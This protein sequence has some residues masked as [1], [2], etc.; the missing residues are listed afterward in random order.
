MIE[1]KSFKIVFKY[2][3]WLLSLL[4]AISCSS[5]LT[6]ISLSNGDSVIEM[7]LGLSA[8]SS[9]AVTAAFPEGVDVKYYVFDR[10][11][12]K[13][14]NTTVS[15]NLSGVKLEIRTGVKEVWA[16]AGLD[17]SRLDSCT[18]IDEFKSQII[19]LEDN[20][21][22]GPFPSSGT[23]TVFAYSKE[24]AEVKLELSYFAVRINVKEIRNA[25]SGPL[26]GSPI[27]VRGFFLTNVPAS[28]KVDGSEPE[29]PGYC[30]IDGRS[31][32]GNIISGKEDADLPD[33]TYLSIDKPCAYGSKLL[34]DAALLLLPNEG[35]GCITRAVA[36][37]LIGD[38]RFFY[39]V[40]L[41]GLKRN[42]SYNL[43]IEITRPG[44]SDPESDVF[45]QAV[46]VSL[47]VQNFI[48]APDE[49]T[50]VF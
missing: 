32:Q 34:P 37:V 48:D 31:S 39:P 24:M 30:N 17:F 14:E 20:G 50:V 35:G 6:D 5:K 44:S 49:I 40:D 4:P 22:D 26:S 45:G 19:L 15:S 2:A 33:L 9:A 42:H 27:Q 18:D 46:G 47:E 11:G 8:R 7:E 10:E 41:N 36:D 28:C 21:L 1:S 3:F 43:E 12:G 23:S 13:L 38:K 16:I 25:L 29:D